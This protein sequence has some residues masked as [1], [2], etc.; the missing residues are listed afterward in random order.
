ML[1]PTPTAI[2]Q[3]GARV[4][5]NEIFYHPP[6][7]VTY[8]P[9]P[10]A[11]A[12]FVE[13]HNA[14]TEPADLGGW[15]F[16]DG[17]S[18]TF[19][20]GTV[21]PPGGFLVLADDVAGFNAYFA[22]SA[23][24]QW[25]GELSNGGERI[26][27]VDELGQPVD[28]ITYTDGGGSP[29]AWSVDADGSGDSLSLLSTENADGT[30]VWWDAATPT[31][32]T[33]NAN[34]GSAPA[35]LVEGFTWTHHPLE[36]E[37]IVVDATVHGG[38]NVVLEYTVGYPGTIG[39][40]LMTDLGGDRFRATIEPAEYAAG[41]LVR[42]RLQMGGTI[43][44]PRDNDTIDWVGTT[45]ADPSVTTD[46]PVIEW[47]T[48]AENYQQ[49]FDED[50][51]TDFDGVLA[52]DGVVYDNVGFR[53]RGGIARSPDWTKRNWKFRLPDHH[54]FFIDGIED[55]LDVLD[56]Q[57]G[58]AD[59]ARI[60]EYLGHTIASEMGLVA[61]RVQHVRLHLNGEFF[62]LHTL[63][64][65]PDA[66]FLRAN[67]LEDATLFKG[68]QNPEYESG[69]TTVGVP[70][71]I[72]W[73]DWDI[74]EYLNLLA[75]ASVIQNNDFGH[76]NF[77]FWYDAAEHERYEGMIWD[78]DMSQGIRYPPDSS[79]TVALEIGNSWSYVWHRWR[80]QA[81]MFAE[82]LEEPYRE[83][84]LRRVRTLADEWFGTGR[85]EQM[86]RAAY[87]EIAP[88]WG[89]DTASWGF[90]GGQAFS[91]QNAIDRLA[92]AWIDQFHAHL[93]G[94][95]PAG[96]LPGPQPE[97]PDL[98]LFVDAAPADPRSEH[99]R[100][101]NNEDVAIDVSGWSLA[102]SATAVLPPG[103]VLPANG[104]AYVVGDDRRTGFRAATTD[105]YVLTE[106]DAPLSDAGGSVE[107]RDTGTTVQAAAGWGTGAPP[108]GLILNEWN[109]VGSSASLLNGDTRF[110]SILGNGGDW[111]E[112]VVVDDHLDLR[113][114]SVGVGD[115]GVD[116]VLTFTD[117]PV[118][119]DL[120]AGTIITVAETEIVGADATV[121]GEDLS[122]RPGAGDWWIHVVG[123][124]RIRQTWKSFF[125]CS[126]TPFA[127]ST[128][129]IAQSAAVSV[130]YV[131][132][133]KSWW[134]GVS[135][136]L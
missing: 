126:S 134:P 37:P 70:S 23:A 98:E 120:R 91:Q 130:R 111:F 95:G 114:W 35:A 61:P 85:F 41:D 129:M 73:E 89:L 122:Y 80:V 65:H 44:A 13:L 74:P 127:A 106:Y 108:S 56:L 16:D 101:Q 63:Q 15:R 52:Y 103:S 40:V 81:P 53:A 78:L 32:G 90:W 113:G 25:S 112:L 1:V 77:Y 55:G 12:E 2:G 17:I 92:D 34:A 71:T 116:Q 5:I 96:D 79:L 67:E 21:L 105:L 7:L 88:E 75:A 128:S 30:S 33:A 133:L 6:C 4:L 58:F 131:S 115:G 48:S 19:L 24:G 8:T 102:G 26:S 83:L 86:A 31:P 110:G 9:C 84:Y 132:S 50:G 107:L 10:D 11:P 18:F 45:I 118:W 97:N 93:T 87:A 49:G 125:V 136:R 36:N 123:V 62:G 57:G 69:P 14:G 72:G 100:I 94:G 121:W 76:D 27:L 66:G 43:L 60:R 20:P 22:T 109:A 82:V 42:F 51:D 54:D 38:S 47:F 135:R 119:S 3:P 64:E 46:L 29:G 39:S 117:A 68:V 99:I 28:A 124:P 104:S 59:E